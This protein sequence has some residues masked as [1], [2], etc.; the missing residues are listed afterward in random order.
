MTLANMRETGSRISFGDLRA[1]VSQFSLY[2]GKN[3]S[4]CALLTGGGI[5]SDSQIA[6]VACPLAPWQTPQCPAGESNERGA[7]RRD[8]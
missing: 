2:V 3:Q 8:S 6:P 4:G 7:I 5:R 1:M